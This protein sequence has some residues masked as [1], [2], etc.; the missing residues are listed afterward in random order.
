MFV[1]ATCVYKCLVSIARLPGCSSQFVVADF[2]ANILLTAT[3]KA[4]VGDY[5]LV[6]VQQFQQNGSFTNRTVNIHGSTLY[7]PPE[8]LRAVVSTKWDVYSFGVVR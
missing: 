2:S 1:A 5:G 8:S 7:M 3:G 4:K 6:R